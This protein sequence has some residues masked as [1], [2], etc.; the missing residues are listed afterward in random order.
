MRHDVVN[1]EAHQLIF[2]N[3]REAS[4]KKRLVCR[5]T[6]PRKKLF[7]HLR[8]SLEMPGRKGAFPAAAI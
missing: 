1:Y 4:E 2:P 3:V 5:K 8:R 7:Q 6:T